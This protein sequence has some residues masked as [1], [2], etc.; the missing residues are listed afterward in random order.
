[1][2]PIDHY[3]LVVDL[4]WKYMSLSLVVVLSLMI[5]TNSANSF[6]DRRSFPQNRLY[7][8]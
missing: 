4:I 1:M 2:L 6:A 5:S 7:P 8:S 3:V